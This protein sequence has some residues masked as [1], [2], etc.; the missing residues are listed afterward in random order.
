MPD[1]AA[2]DIVLI[3]PRFEASYWGLEYALPLFGKRAAMPV[4]SLP[5]LA[6]LTPP[7]HRVTILDENIE[8]LDF[9]L[10]ARADIVGVTG[11]SVQRARMREI[12]GELK[13]RDAFTVVGGPWVSV[14]ERY[15]ADLSRTIFVGEAEETWPAFLDDWKRGSTRCRY[16]QTARTDMSRVP[17]P[18]YE[19]LDMQHYL[20]G[21]IQ[22][23]RGCPFQCEFCDIIVTFG[24]VPRLKTAAQIIAELEALRARRMEIVFIVDDN[25]IGNKKAVTP[26]LE[27]LGA[28]QEANG[29]PFVFVTEASLDLA[30]DEALMRLMIDANI[31]SVFIGIESPNEASLV[32]TKKHQNVKAR[33]T[34]VDRVRAVQQSG[35]E[36]WS[37]M[38]LGFDHDDDTIFAAQREFLREARIAQAM[39][40]MLYA[41]PKTPL[42][43]RL[44][45]IGRLDP[46]DDSPFGTN[47]L[48]ARLSREALRDGYVRLMEEIYDPDAYFE[49]LSG[50]LGNGSAPFAPA[51]A[52][53]WQRHPLARLKGQ[54]WNLARAA[55]L[56]ARLMRLVDDVGLRK[57]YRREVGREFLSRRDP[58]HLFGYLIRCAMHYHHHTLAR[59]MARHHSALVNSF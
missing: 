36:V 37:G 22:F 28:W 41:I 57:R 30:E 4:A 2:A 34:I 35:L 33:R 11:M 52:R 47:V 43:A 25:L 13:R 53:Y 18:R 15:F 12:L 21:S 3:N 23:S 56:Y 9:D 49:R 31:L 7:E 45:A 10:I 26:L 24:R 32:E 6:A 19:L 8:P 17:V 59:Q 51:R 40:G 1:H 29:F 54:A 14:H 58:G 50:C 46:D 27:T 44:A 55:A 38:I 48:P 39:V 42:H 5:L 20:F 16:E